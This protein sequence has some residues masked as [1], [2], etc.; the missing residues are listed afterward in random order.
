MSTLNPPTPEVHQVELN[1]IRAASRSGTV[2]RFVPSEW[3]IDFAYD[4]EHLPLPE[5]WK[6]LKRE[7]LAEIK[8]YSNLEFTSFHN[9]FFMDYFGIPHA[10]SHMPPEVPFIDI[11]AAKAALPGNGDENKVVFTYTKDVAKFVRKAI[12]STDPWP[13]SRL[14]IILFSIE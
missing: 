3:A 4:D 12:E 9:G 7:A 5:P 13:V 6:A 11:A 2:K 8:K 1:L 10:P 14:Q